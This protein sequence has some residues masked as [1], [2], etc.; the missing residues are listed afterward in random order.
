MIG[1]KKQQKGFTLMEILVV[2]GISVVLIV[3]IVN[4]FLL[5]LRAQRFSAQRQ[6][7]LS[8]IRF[9][10]EHIAR[11]VRISEVD[12]GTPGD[13]KYALDGEEGIQFAEQELYLIDED[14]KEF[15]YYLSAGEVV[16]SISKDGVIEQEVALNNSEDTQVT[17]FNF[18]IVPIKNPFFQDR[19]N[20]AFPL[21]AG[22]LGVNQCTVDD[23]SK[24]YTG[25]CTCSSNSQCITG[26]CSEGICV[27]FD[28]QPR[29]SMM[30]EFTPAGILSGSQPRINLQTTV[31][32]RIYKR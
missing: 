23:P 15:H 4:V 28:T 8:N 10:A 30:F 16:L 1:N 29:V 6:A 5:A 27:P 31:N 18:F 9:V 25:F 7:T 32:S 22:C 11:Q 3:V 14:G 13:G 19:C 17:K 2:L 20:D 26:R 12:Y 21:S 24:G